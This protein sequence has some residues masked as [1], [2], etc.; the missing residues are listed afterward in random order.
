M[1]PTMHRA[2][3]HASKAAVLLDVLCFLFCS[4][5]VSECTTGS[6]GAAA[7]HPGSDGHCSTHRATAAAICKDT[8]NRGT[9]PVLAAFPHQADP[10]ASVVS[11][12][13]AAWYRAVQQT[14]TR[15]HASVPC[16][17]VRAIRCAGPVHCMQAGKQERPLTYA[18]IRPPLQPPPSP[19][20]GRAAAQ[21]TSVPPTSSSPPSPTAAMPTAAPKQ[22]APPAKAPSPGRRRRSLAAETLQAATSTSKPRRTLQQATGKAPGTGTPPMRP[23]PAATPATPAAGTPA[24][25]STP[26]PAASISAIAA[27]APLQLVSLTPKIPPLPNLSAGLPPAVATPG[28]GPPPPPVTP[29]PLATP[30]TAGLTPAPT[31]PLP[32]AL[33]PIPMGVTLLQVGEN[34][35]NECVDE[36]APLPLGRDATT[37]RPFGGGQT[38]HHLCLNRVPS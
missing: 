22:G 33:K 6:S 28:Q 5:G 17:L 10:A 27:R 7:T 21:E 11:G 35:I 34:I 2:A 19:P 24:A 31:T 29:R 16:M 12:H 8:N 9:P 14:S 37:L 36:I 23:Q 20:D 15:V 38:W 18:Q 4:A 32:A 30:T 13:A 25:T 26:A 1:H 3:A